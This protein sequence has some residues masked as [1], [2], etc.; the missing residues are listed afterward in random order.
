MDFRNSERLRTALRLAQLYTLQDCREENK[1]RD[2][3]PRE[4]PLR[5]QGGNDVADVHP[6]GAFVYRMSRKGKDLQS[7]A[8]ALYEKRF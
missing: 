3:M 6:N 1:I 5:R 8:R 2:A 4:E 7:H